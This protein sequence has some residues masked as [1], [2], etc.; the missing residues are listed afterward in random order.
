M[1]R[2]ELIGNVTKDV[3][4]TTTSNGT[5]VSNFNLAVNR[6]YA[7]KDGNPVT[8]FHACVAFNKKAEVL[9]SYVKKGNKLY[10]AGELYYDTY[11]DNKGVKRTVAKINVDD[12]EFLTPKKINDFESQQ[13]EELT[14]IDMSDDS[15]PF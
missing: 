4:I 3:D 7:D 2:I 11:E 9:A 14:P 1:N 13:K 15:L 5:K 10:I 8:D 6:R 12:F